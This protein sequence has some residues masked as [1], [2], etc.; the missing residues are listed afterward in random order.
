MEHKLTEREDRI[1]KAFCEYI[2]NAP[3]GV[4]F[5]LYD[6]QG[7]LRFA[8]PGIPAQQPYSMYLRV[9]IETSLLQKVNGVPDTYLPLVLDKKNVGRAARRRERLSVLKDKLICELIGRKYFD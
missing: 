3:E 6:L 4:P 1:V 2:R 7:A 8:N 5:Q 9:A